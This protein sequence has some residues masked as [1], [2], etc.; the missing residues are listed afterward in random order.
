M[1]DEYAS[2]EP[3]EYVWIVYRPPLTST[4]GDVEH[5]GAFDSAEAAKDHARAADR[6]GAVQIQELRV[7]DGEGP[8]LD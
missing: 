1:P 4:T 8:K 5:L 2:G 6:K 3:I 7:S